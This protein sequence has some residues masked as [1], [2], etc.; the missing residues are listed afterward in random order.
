MKNVISLIFVLVG[1]FSFAQT[2]SEALKKEQKKI[3]IKIQNTKSLL[4]KV[5]TNSEASLNELRLMDNQIRSREELVRIFDNQV[6]VAEVKMIERKNEIEKLN[7]RLA[8]LKRQYKSMILYTYKHR[9]NIGKIMFILSANN[10]NDA[11]KRNKYLKKVAGLQKKQRA[12][13]EQHQQLIADE[14]TKIDQEKQAKLL[15]LEEKRKEREQ[16]EKDKITKQ[17]TYQQFKKE[18]QKL[19]SQLQQEER[20]KLELKGKI[21]AAIKAE[22]AENQRRQKETAGKK[23]STSKKTKS[24]SGSSSS[25]TEEKPERE[26]VYEETTEGKVVAK[27]FEGNKGRLPW[28]VDNGTITERYGRNAHPTLEGVFTNNNGIDISCAKGTSVR[29]IFEGE[30]TSVFSITGAGKVVIIKH[31]NYRTVYSNLADVSVQ[32]GSKVTTKQIIGH[33]L[34]SDGNVSICHFEVHLVNNN[35]TQSLNPSLWVGR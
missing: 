7:K 24:T 27:N 5:K 34:P 21:D 19:V 30:V 23:K 29:S 8:D 10:Y 2:S 6:R 25:S 3:E 18:E 31:G 20:K 33:L 16:I 13:I 35:G 28:P 22:I 15:A 26:Y 9:N 14:I 1:I 32:T 4:K 11:I 17:Q 12:L